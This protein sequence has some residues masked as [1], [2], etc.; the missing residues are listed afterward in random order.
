MVDVHFDCMVCLHN[1]GNFKFIVILSEMV[2]VHFDWFVYKILSAN[3]LFSS[4]TTNL[5]FP[6]LD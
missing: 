5:K 4:V 3:T 2:Y 6:A 1:N